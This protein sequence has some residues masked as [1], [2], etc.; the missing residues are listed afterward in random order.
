MLGLR[1]CIGFSL[2]ALSGGYFLVA[3]LGILIVENELEWSTGSKTLGL[4]QLW[5]PDSTAQAQ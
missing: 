2:V 1:C 4:R 3:L 5:L